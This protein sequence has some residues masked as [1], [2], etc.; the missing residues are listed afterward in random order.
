LCFDL[1]IVLKNIVKIHVLEL[2][3]PGGDNEVQASH[4][5]GC[6]CVAH[7]NDGDE[8]QSKRIWK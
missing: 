2:L 3:Y 8:D 4:L 5:L 1:L 6:S 7:D